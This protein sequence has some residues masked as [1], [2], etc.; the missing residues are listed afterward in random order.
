MVAHRWSFGLGLA[1]LLSSIAGAGEGNRLTYLDESDP[2]YVSRSFPRLITPQWIGEDGVEAVVVLAIDDMRDPEKYEQFPRPILQ[3]LKRIDGRAPVSIMTNQI[4]PKHSRLQAWLKEGLSLETHT[5]DHP[6]PFFKGGDFD[7]ARSTYERCV[8]LM[9]EIPNSRPVAFRMP[10]CDSLNT[11]SPRFYAEMF[12]RTTDKG[13]FLT[14]DS[15]VFNLLTSNDPELPRKLVIDED[16]QD[17]FRKYLPKD[18]TFVNTIEN[19]PYPYVLGQLCW[20]FPCV[21]PS[22]WVAQHRHQPNNP[23][24]VSDWKAALDITVLKRG[25]FCLVFHPHGW[26]R[27][28]QIVDLIDYA[29]TKYGKKVRFLTFREAQERMDKNLLDGQSLRAADGTDNGVRLVDLDNDGYLDVVIGNEKVKQTRRWS[30]KTQTWTIGDLPPSLAKA[31]ARFGVAHS[32][33]TAS[34]ILQNETDSGA[35]HYTDGKWVEDQTLLSGL[36][37]E[38][39][40]ILTAAKGQD[41][42]VRLRDLDGDGRC[43]LIVSNDKE[44]T[45]FARSENKWRKLPFGLPEGTS[46]VNAAGQDN[47]LRFADID[48]DGRDDVVFSNEECFLVYLFASMNDGWSRRV[49]LARRSDPDMLPAIARNGTNNGAFFHSRHLWVNNERTVRL[50][51][52]VDRLSF[53]D[54]LATMAPQ[55]KTPKA[56]L[57]SIRPRP[58]FQVELIACEPLVQSPIAFAWGPDG[59]FWVVEMGDYP[60]GM[61]NKGKPGGRIKYLED[62]DG[63]GRYDKATVF[64]DGL[65]FPTS[66]LPWRKGVLVTCAPE[67]FYAEDSKGTG[68]ADVRVPLFTGF[69][70]GNP[71]HRVNSLVWGLDNWIYCAN[72]DS[73]G[74]IKSVKTGKE[75]GLSGRDLRIRP[76]DGAVDAQAGQTQYGRSRNDWGDWFGC[77]NGNPMY[78]FALADQYIRRNRS[79]AAPDARVQVS[80]TPGAARVFPV[81]RTVTRFNDPH[82]L[83]HFTSAC[84]AIV[85]RDDLFGPAFSRSSFV[86]EPVHN[87]IHREILSAK[88]VTFT[89][90]RAEDEQESE[91]LASSDNW[92]RP[93]SIQ[94]GPDGALWV[95]DM[96]RDIIEHPEWIPTDWQRRLDLRAGA[97]KGRIYRVYPVGAALRKIPRLDRLDTAGLVAALDSPNG[98]QRDTAQQMLLWRKDASAIPLLEKLTTDCQ[99]PVCRLHALCTLDGLDA[100]SLALLLRALSDSHP[101]VRRH[102]VRLCEGRLTK[103]PE[104]AE[105]LLKRVDD[106]DP[107]VRMQLA[108]MLGE[109]DNERAGVALGRLA[110][111]DADDR[112]IRAAILSSVNRKNLDHVLLAVMKGSDKKPPPAPLIESLLRLA[113]AFGDTNAL[114]TLLRAIGTPEKDRYAPWQFTTLAGL[115]DSLDERDKPLSNLANDSNGELKA[116]LKQVSGLFAA[117]RAALAAGQSRQDEKERA[118]RILGRGLDHQQEDMSA[119]AE[120]LVPQTPEGMQSAAVS[121]LARLRSPRVPQL[122][123]RGWKALVPELRRQVLGVLLSRET[124]VSALLDAMESKSIAPSEID[125]ALRQRLLE[126]RSADVRR[127]ATKLFADTVNTDR[128]K[129]IDSYRSILTLSGD[130]KRGAEVFRKSCAA[131]HKLGD[132]GNAVGPDLATLGDKSTPAVLIAVLDPNRAV[133][134]RYVGYTA[135]TKGGLTF[136]GVLAAETGNSITLVSTDGKQ[137]VILRSDLEELTSTGKSAMPEGLEKDIKPQDLADLIAHIHSQ[138][139]QPQRKT[140]EGNQPALVRTSDDGSMLLTSAN[141]EIYGPTVIFEKQYGNLGYWTSPNDRA[142]WTVEVAKPGRY[143]VW[144]DWACHPDTAGKKFLLQAGVNQ[145]T[146]IVKSTGSWENYRQGKVGEIVLAEGRQQVTLRSATKIYH[147]M[148]DLKS[149]KFVPMPKE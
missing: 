52:N 112:Y 9:S 12:N 18:R 118:I 39:R 36:E 78:Q 137:N 87:L 20:E 95:A 101:G 54:L 10:C 57:H 4:D 132:I 148:I 110:L 27:N 111:H 90:R 149:V 67:I 144:L 79:L 85:Y 103:T 119:L 17:R 76:D 30:A 126:H 130:A 92:F 43:E 23:V 71:Q 31:G 91:F 28:E 41:R 128:Q 117:A 42:G 6:C 136:T 123:L 134:A 32:D 56:S 97:D 143:S 2:Y 131:C 73:G 33:G 21:M 82:T 115:L 25:V 49:V 40:K 68:K 106:D 124:W 145:M 83:N 55:A 86:S 114:A 116:A 94:T 98:W 38:G 58:G 122:L 61:E 121:A 81:S 51:D 65:S 59:K 69:I 141:C 48:E 120:L 14:I 44:Q 62:T 47:G 60:L 109:W 35:W 88:G 125:A 142:V 74:R 24:T 104:L 64:L 80:V 96:Y 129:V 16:G 53:N 19:Y 37:I 45:I 46:I 113:N 11:P 105:A 108:Y 107:H 1:L 127:R 75:I 70:P 102:A 26:I 140:F 5:I 77:N 84:S 89:S 72:G 93:T 138:G 146:G 13:R 133:E 15:S 139:P 63:D 100:L 66:V 8:D 7:K 50:K 34:M 3:R 99:R 135:T 147:P 29:V 22:D